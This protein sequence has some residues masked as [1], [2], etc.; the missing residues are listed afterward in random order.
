ML[1]VDGSCFDH[2]VNENL[3]ESSRKVTFDEWGRIVLEW[4]FVVGRTKS[5]TCGDEFDHLR[6]ILDRANWRESKER[7]L[8]EFI[9]LCLEN[10]F[11]GERL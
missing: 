10:K 9:F 1:Q 8:V 4:E 5:P 3:V 11:E 2:N 7:E 6:C